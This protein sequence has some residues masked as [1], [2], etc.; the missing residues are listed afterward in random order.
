MF[1]LG[2]MRAVMHSLSGL[3]LMV[4]LTAALAPT[5]FGHHLPN[6]EDR[7]SQAYAQAG[8]DLA[9]ICGDGTSD[10]SAS[11]GDCPVCH[12]VGA[13]LPPPAGLSLH[14]ADLIFVAKLVAPRESKALQRVR[15][16]ALGLRAP[17]TV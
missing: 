12:I 1:R 13:A 11:S 3:V 2:M 7:I 5:G 9:D 4:L 16:P 15:D 14:D 10:G 6:Q 8:F 17:P